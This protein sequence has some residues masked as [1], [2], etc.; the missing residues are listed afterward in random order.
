MPDIT[1]LRIDALIKP[2]WLRP[3]KL[4]KKFNM[5][6]ANQLNA[7]VKILEVW[8]ALHLDNYPLTINR[9]DNSTI[10]V[11]TR[12]DVSRRPIEIGKTIMSQKTCVSDAIHVWNKAPIKVTES[13][14][15]YQ[16]KKAIREYALSLPA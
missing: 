3:V 4:L 1:C 16:A 11:N 10:G 5:L 14:T 2:D 13:S 8:K 6:S 7:S 12:A 9:Q 15:I